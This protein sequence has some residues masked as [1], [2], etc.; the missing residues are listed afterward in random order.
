LSEQILHGVTGYVVAAG[1]YDGFVAALAA[2]GHDPA[3]RNRLGVAAARHVASRYDIATTAR[4]YEALWHD[5]R[6]RGAQ[7]SRRQM[8]V[9]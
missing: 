2:L 9:G 5:D 4:A 6:R 1:D 7:A 3:L 8:A